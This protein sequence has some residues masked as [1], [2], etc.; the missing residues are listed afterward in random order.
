MGHVEY[1]SN[2]QDEQGYNIPDEDTIDDHVDHVDY[3]DNCSWLCQLRALHLAGMQ[4]MEAKEKVFIKCCVYRTRKSSLTFQRGI[5][6]LRKH[7]MKVT[8]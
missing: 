2:N 3:E 5:W 7:G 1:R 6:T 4:D 8:N